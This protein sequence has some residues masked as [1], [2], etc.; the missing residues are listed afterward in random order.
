MKCYVCGA[1][2]VH[3]HGRSNCCPK[4]I[5]FLQM[6]KTAKSDGKYVPSL[7]ELDSLVP[8]KMSCPLCHKTMHWIDDKNRPLGAIL[9][10]YRNGT[11]GITCHSCNVK[12]GMMVGDSYC[13]VP[14]G[15][16]LCRACKTIKRLSDFYVRRDSKN[17]EYPMSKCKICSKESYKSWRQKN[18]DQYKALTKKHNVKRSKKNDSPSI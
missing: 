3:R 1:D 14:D 7:Y 10:H 2:A 9:Q 16:K 8:A 18:P 6:Q 15:H 11:I 17:K 4:H 13:D 5:R 12:H